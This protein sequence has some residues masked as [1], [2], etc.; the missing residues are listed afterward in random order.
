MMTLL[1]TYL[2]QLFFWIKNKQPSWLTEGQVLNNEL[3]AQVD[4]ESEQK[5]WS[6]F[7]QGI[8]D[9]LRDG[10]SNPVV[11]LHL[12]NPPRFMQYIF[13]LQNKKRPNAYLSKSSYGNQR[14]SLHHLFCVQN[15]TG[16]ADAFV[17]CIS[18]FSLHY[19]KSIS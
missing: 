12:I 2:G 13:Q 3:Y 15:R 4:G 10:N 11:H 16:F 18:R 7:L 5:Y 19:K 8:C 9:L 1:M 6:R 17:V 14:S